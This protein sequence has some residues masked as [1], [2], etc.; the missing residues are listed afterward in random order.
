MIIQTIVRGFENDKHFERQ[1][2]PRAPNRL[3]IDFGYAKTTRR[4]WFLTTVHTAK[5]GLG[6]EMAV[7]SRQCPAG[8][9]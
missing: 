4:K 6:L 7:Q 9:L 5:V 1:K 8:W 3:F 2:G